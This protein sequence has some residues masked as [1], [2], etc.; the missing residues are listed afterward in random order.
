MDVDTIRIEKLTP[1]E[2]QRCF[3]NNLCFKVANQDTG[4]TNATTHS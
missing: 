3:D 1:E 2:R 4:P